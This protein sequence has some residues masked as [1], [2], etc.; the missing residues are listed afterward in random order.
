[1]YWLWATLVGIVNSQRPTTCMRLH[2]FQV[3]LPVQALKWVSKAR[4]CATSRQNMALSKLAGY[5]HW[6][7]LVRNNMTNGS[8]VGLNTNSKDNKKDTKDSDGRWMGYLSVFI[9]LHSML[10]K[11][12]SIKTVMPDMLNVTDLKEQINFGSLKQWNTCHT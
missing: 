6:G 1:M 4:K 8:T 11:T 2:L 9:I 12:T 10:L 7:C 5:W 3:V